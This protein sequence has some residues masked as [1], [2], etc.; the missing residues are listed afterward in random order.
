LIVSD[1]QYE[2]ITIP[3]ILYFQKGPLRLFYTVYTNPAKRLKRSAS[4]TV[5]SDVTK[6]TSIV[7][8]TCNNKVSG[9]PDHSE[10]QISSTVQKTTK[11]DDNLPKID[12]KKSEC[13]PNSNVT[14]SSNCDEFVSSSRVFRLPPSVI[15]NFH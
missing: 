15:S 8:M 1:E 11:I 6:D 5:T 12:T 7:E 9:P 3:F 14:S 2:A 13:L 4:S 10:K